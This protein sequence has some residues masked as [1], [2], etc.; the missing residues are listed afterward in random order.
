MAPASEAGQLLE[1]LLPTSSWSGISSGA[2]QHWKRH[3][4]FRMYLLKRLTTMPAAIGSPI[5]PKPG[6]AAGVYIRLSARSCK[7]MGQLLT[8]AREA[9]VSCLLRDEDI[10][11][12]ARRCVEHHVAHIREELAVDFSTCCHFPRGN[13]RGLF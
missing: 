2:Q 7:D 8:T 6:I 4:P 5:D 13:N 1:L 12:A 11:R 10:E 9:V 3:R